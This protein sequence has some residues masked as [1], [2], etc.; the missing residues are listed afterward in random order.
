MHPGWRVSPSPASPYRAGA[1][2]I[3]GCTL[4]AAPGSFQQFSCVT[5]LD[6]QTVIRI[7]GVTV[8]FEDEGRIWGRP[9]L[10]QP[11]PGQLPNRLES[12][13][14]PSFTFTGSTDFSTAL[15]FQFVNR[16]LRS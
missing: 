15:G 14:V 1:F 16:Q 12:I 3:R 10:R 6:R 5:P 4:E 8:S 7:V 11:H 2:S 13:G 9:R